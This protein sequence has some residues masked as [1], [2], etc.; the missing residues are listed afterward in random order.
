M[1]PDLIAALGCALVLLVISSLVGIPMIR[2]LILVHEARHELRQ[3]SA[4]FLRTMAGWG[5][6]L[7][8]LLLTWF[9][10]T[11]LGDWG[12]TGDLEGAIDRSWLRLRIVLEILA[13][14]ADN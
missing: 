1:T 10:A 13:A 3:G 6:I 12:V 4:G 2:K 9:A 14:F 7:V 11:V 8:W 5:M